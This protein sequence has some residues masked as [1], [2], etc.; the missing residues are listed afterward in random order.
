MGAAI[1]LR[2]D[3]DAGRL[4]CLAKFSRDGARSRRLLALARAGRKG[5]REPVA[6][7]EFRIAKRQP[8]PMPTDP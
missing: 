5:A 3:F 1:R 8:W 2:E 7:R 6:V 4:R